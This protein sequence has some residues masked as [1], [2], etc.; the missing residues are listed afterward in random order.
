MK[1]TQY[2]GVAVESSD[3]AIGENMGSLWRNAVEDLALS[4]REMAGGRGK[5]YPIQPHLLIIGLA[6]K[7]K[8]T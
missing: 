7:T 1:D 5:F 6:M 3:H 8:R 2:A 4:S